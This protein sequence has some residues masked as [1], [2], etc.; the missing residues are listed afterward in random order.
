MH[1]SRCLLRLRPFL[2]PRN[3]AWL[4]IATLAVLIPLSRALEPQAPQDARSAAALEL[5]KKIIEDVKQNKEI[6]PNLTYLSDVIGP[7]LTGSENLDR[8]S[9]V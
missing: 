9:V 6:I 5:D 7:R 4:A 3:A 1:H 8:K 2:A